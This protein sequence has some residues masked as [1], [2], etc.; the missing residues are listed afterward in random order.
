MQKKVIQSLLLAA[1]LLFFVFCSSL[2]HTTGAGAEIVEAID[3][4]LM[5][6][7]KNFFALSAD[8]SVA[9]QSSSLPA[10][11]LSGF[12]YHFGR[13]AAGKKENVSVYGFTEFPVTKAFAKK[14]EAAAI[15]DSIEFVYDTILDTLRDGVISTTTRFR[16]FSTDT[17]NYYRLSQPGNDATPLCTL[18]QLPDSGSYYVGR[19]ADSTFTDSIF[20]LCRSY[21]VCMTDTT[22]K[23]KSG[24]DSVLHDCD[25]MFNDS[26]LNKS[27]FISLFSTG[28]ELAWF[29]FAPAMVI[30]SHYFATDKDSTITQ[31]DTLR[32]ISSLVATEEDSLIAAAAAQPFSTSLSKRTAV[33]KLDLTSLWDTMA[34]TGFDE[35]LSA[36]VTLTMKSVTV[37]TASGDTSWILFFLSDQFY[38]DGENLDKE[39]DTQAAAYGLKSRITMVKL[40]DDTLVLP[41]GHHLQHYLDKKSDDPYYLYVR[42]KSNAVYRNQKILWDT[43]WFKAVLST[44]N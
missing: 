15:L 8:S 6:F 42:L 30:H 18:H 43:P 16:L 19:L 37:D 26:T 12:G 17:S 13:L 9:A 34:S 38:T 31:T 25:S 3:P 20:N 23:S 21:N 28:N 41:V 11:K 44:I 1:I 29:K 27:F 40:V 35:I 2:D 32:G 33:F 24:K 22:G 14:I 7:E 4:A 39:F 5:N 10:T 36:A